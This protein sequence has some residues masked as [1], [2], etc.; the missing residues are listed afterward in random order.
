MK[1]ILTLAA[2]V[3]ATACYGQEVCPE[4]WTACGEGT[5]WDEVSQTCVVANVSDT[6]FD[7]CV[8][9]NDFL[10]HLSNFGFGCGSEV[11]WTCGEPWEYQGYSY[12]TTLIGEQCWFAENLRV[13]LYA[14]GD[15]IP[16]N[17]SLAQWS[18]ATAGAVDNYGVRW[19]ANCQD[20]ADDPAYDIEACDPEVS[21]SEYGLLYNAYAVVDS[22]GLC[23]TGWT[24]PAD[25]EWNE[26]EV[27]LGMD[28]DLALQTGVRGSEHGNQL[29]STFGWRSGANGSDNFGFSA[30]GGGLVN[31]NG[32]YSDAGWQGAYWS[33]SQ[34]A[35]GEPYWFMRGFRYGTGGV[36]RADYGARN[37]MAVRCVQNPE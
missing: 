22:R 2:L 23:P 12:Q 15:Q 21:L 36:D 29:R 34:R 16:N 8:G 31:N 11:V 6:D 19:G 37:G 5:V 28:P 25:H 24:V 32:D 17:L 20:Y 3:F 9:I 13:E 7:G 26:L 33:S 35:S 18:T 4:L 27:F 14:S 30:V 10:V 1:H